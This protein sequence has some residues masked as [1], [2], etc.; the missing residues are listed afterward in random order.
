MVIGGG[1]YTNMYANYFW[2]ENKAKAFAAGEVVA[3]VALDKIVVG[4][5]MKVTATVKFFKA[6][7]HG[8]KFNLAIYL[9]EDEVRASQSTTNGLNAGYI[10]RNVFRSANSSTYNGV[11][12]NNG[13]AISEN[14]NFNF[15]FDLPLDTTWVYHQLKVIG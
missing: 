7:Q 3:G 2:V 14:Q 9:A 13:S 12:I 4:S 8:E 11:P 1:A 10:H 15:S 6:Q 5:S